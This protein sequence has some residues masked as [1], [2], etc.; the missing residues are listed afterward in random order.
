MPVSRFQ[1]IAVAEPRL[2]ARLVRQAA[3]LDATLVLDLEDALWDVT[4]DARTAQLKA[5]GR[6]NLVALAAADPELFAAQRVGVRV[7][8]LVGPHAA[9]DLEALAAVSRHA[10]LACVVAAKV[11]T[12]DDL[13]AWLAAL[14][15]AK[16]AHGGVVP[17]IETVAGMANLQELLTRAKATGIE[18]IVYGHYDHGLD[19]GWWPIPDLDSDRFWRVAL[20]F[21]DQVESAGLHYV[22]APFFQLHQPERFANILRRLLRACRRQPGAITLG[23]AQTTIAATLDATSAT[24]VAGPGG[25]SDQSDPIDLARHIVASYTANR[26]PA[27]SFA[28]DGRSGEF[29][30]PHLYLAAQ[31][32]LRAADIDDG[33]AHD[34]HVAS[35]D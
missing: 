34:P 6:R 8:R 30:S 3:A 28:V 16:V 24:P 18:W 13:D 2:T 26:R 23:L 7:N 31:N 14:D 19:A 20:P 17:I 5:E 11:E 22:Q 21:I 25:A 27:A 32:Y 35:D 1:F 12:A 4:D 15:R 9:A 29:I 10:T 33:D